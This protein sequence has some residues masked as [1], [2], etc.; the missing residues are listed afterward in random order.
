MSQKYR[1]TFEVDDYGHNFLCP[2]RKPKSIQDPT[3]LLEWITIHV[4]SIQNMCPDV[5]V[6][7]IKRSGMGFH[8]L[9][10]ECKPLTWDQYQAILMLLPFDNTWF[11]WSTVFT[12]STLRINKKIVVKMS[13]DEYSKQ[14]GSLIDTAKPQTIRL[15]FP[16]PYSRIMYR[17]EIEELYG[18]KV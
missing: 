9:F 15:I 14:L 12:R 4:K 13:G 7:V 11:G 1:L 16:P 2:L 6:A 8:G 17:A 18:D 5:G 3:E 10:P